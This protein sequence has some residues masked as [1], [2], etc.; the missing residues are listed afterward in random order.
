MKK[1]S[2]HGGKRPNAGRKPSPYKTTT[3]SVRVRVEWVD[4]IKKAIANK[5]NEL[6]N[7]GI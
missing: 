7:K 6:K 2:N 3:V 4:T 5:I 1:K